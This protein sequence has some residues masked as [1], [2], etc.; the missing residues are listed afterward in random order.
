MHPSPS[1]YGEKNN[2][3]TIASF[4]GKSDFNVSKR[5]STAVM[6]ATSDYHSGTSS[7]EE[8]TIKEPKTIPTV[9]NPNSIY[10]VFVCVCVCHA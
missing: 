9:S 1:R 3:F 10:Q 7:D 2:P 8:T 6:K 4:V 5:I